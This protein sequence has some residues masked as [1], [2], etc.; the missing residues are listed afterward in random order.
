MQKWENIYRSANFGQKSYCIDDQNLNG[1]FVR[2][3]MGR[4]R[5]PMAIWH[6][7]VAVLEKMLGFFCHKIQLKAIRDSLSNLNNLCGRTKIPILVINWLIWVFIKLFG[8][9]FIILILFQA[10]P[11][12]C[13]H[14]GHFLASCGNRFSEVI[15]GIKEGKNCCAL[16]Q[17]PIL[18]IIV[19]N[20]HWDRNKD[21]LTKK[22][23][24]N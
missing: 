15:Q 18:S 2:P 6:T 5:L 4:Y 16:Q 8:A 22:G 12:L 3:K 19:L 10:D 1:P 20:F 24:L 14:K 23:F 9:S 21:Q 17:Q 7:V 13:G 11:F